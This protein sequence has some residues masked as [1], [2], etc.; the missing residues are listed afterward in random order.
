MLHQ[1]PE[2]LFFA[3]LAHVAVAAL[4][5]TPGGSSRTTEAGSCVGAMQCSLNGDCLE[6]KCVCD[7]AWAGSDDCAW[8]PPSLNI[9]TPMNMYT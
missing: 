4:A 9:G 7:A 8:P 2:M 1:A 3:M 6:G 5:A